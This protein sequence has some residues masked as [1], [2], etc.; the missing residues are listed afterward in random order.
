VFGHSE[1]FK[2][3]LLCFLE[4]ASSIFRYTEV[5]VELET[6]IAWIP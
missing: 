6:C 1:G 3:V 4:I 2:V 5:I